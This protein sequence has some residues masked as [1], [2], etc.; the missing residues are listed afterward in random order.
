[1]WNTL[2]AAGLLLFKKL[3]SLTG[4]I[5]SEMD[6]MCDAAIQPLVDLAELL[7]QVQMRG[8]NGIRAQ[9]GN[10]LKAR[11]DAGTLADENAT[12]TA[13]REVFR[14]AVFDV[15]SVL[16]VEYWTKMAAALTESTLQSVLN[17]FNTTIWPEVEAPLKALEEAIPDPLKNAGLKIVPLAQTIITILITKGVNAG[18][19][20]L[21]LKIEPSLWGGF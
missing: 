3:Y 6:G 9:F 7:Y 8:L 10:D 5:R 21:W 4:D 18:M 20:K 2:P 14:K 17:F 19:L 12:R 11:L 16:A 15:V 13:V 1:M